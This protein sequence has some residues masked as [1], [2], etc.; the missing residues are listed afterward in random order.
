MT[1][2]TNVLSA[3]GTFIAVLVALW[4]AIFGPRRVTKP[5][6]SVMIRPEAPDC[7]WA[8][9]GEKGMRDTG[10]GPGHYVVRPR[11]IN[12]GNEDARNAEVLMIRLWVINDDGK[13]SVDPL[14]LPLVLRWS[15]WPERSVSPAVLPRLLPGTS[16][17]YDLFV[18]ASEQSPRSGTNQRHRN[19]TAG[20]PKTWIAFQTAYDSLD[21]DSIQHRMR[22]QPGRYQLDFAVAASNAKTIY[23]TAHISFSGWRDNRAEMFGEDGGLHIEITKTPKGSTATALSSMKVHYK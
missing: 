5:K 20:R 18:V 14:F 16:K 9:S 21:D 10:S 22:K 23:R 13:W 19:E 17:N 12:Y 15:W 4:V 1:G 2:W 3:I 6:L 8:S 11:V 7:V